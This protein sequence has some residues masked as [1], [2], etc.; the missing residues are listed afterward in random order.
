MGRQGSAVPNSARSAKPRFDGSRDAVEG[1]VVAKGGVVVGMV[2]EE[3]F[4]LV[5]ERVGD[6]E[7]LAR[8]TTAVELSA[9]GSERRRLCSRRYQ[10]QVFEQ[11]PTGVFEQ[12]NDRVQ[13]FDMQTGSQ[14]R[15]P[16]QTVR[17]LKGPV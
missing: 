3:C 4:L 1:V 9:G 10:F 11:P 16:R 15:F 8:A 5:R 14:E 6:L 7:T 12:Q 13:T 17:H 2:Q